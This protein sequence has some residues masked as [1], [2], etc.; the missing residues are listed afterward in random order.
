MPHNLVVKIRAGDQPEGEEAATEAATAYDSPDDIYITIKDEADLVRAFEEADKANQLVQLYIRADK[1]AAAAMIPEYMVDMADPRQS[2]TMQMVSFYRFFPEPKDEAALDL[3]TKRLRAV[4]EPFGALGRI[5]VAS[6]GINAQMAVPA[7]VFKNFAAACNSLD[8]LKGVFLN[9]DRQVAMDVYQEDPAFDALHVR[10]REQ[11]VADGGL[12]EVK[13]YDWQDCGTPMEPEEWHAT[14]DDPNVIVLDCRNEFESEVGRFVSSEPLNTS[15]FRESWDVLKTRL[16]DVPKD[17]PI[18][19]Y[20]TGGIRCIKVGAYLKQELGFANVARLEGGIVSYAR[21]L[22]EKTGQETGLPNISP[23]VGGVIPGSKFKGINYVFDNRLGERITEDVLSECDQCGVASDVYV[24]CANPLCHVRF[25]QCS[26]CGSKFNA[27]CSRGCMQAVE[28]MKSRP[29]PGGYP[30]PPKTI[31]PPGVE[32]SYPLGPM[33]LGRSTSGA[34]VASTAARP[35]KRA[36]LQPGPFQNAALNRAFDVAIDEFTAAE[37]GETQEPDLLARL[38]QETNEAFPGGAHMVSG[39]SQGRLLSSITREIGARHVLEIGTFT[40]YATLCLAEG[41]EAKGG[42]VVTL[43]IDDRAGTIARKY[44]SESPDGSKVDLKIE[45]AMDYLNRLAAMPEEDR[46]S[47]DIILLDGDKKRYKDYYEMILGNN[48]LSP[49][50]LMIADNVLWKGLVPE[51]ARRRAM[52]EELPVEE[53]EAM[54]FTKRQVQLADVL[55]DFNMHVRGDH[56]TEQSYIPIRDGLLVIRWKG[57]ER[58]ALPK[59]SS[60]E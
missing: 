52:G 44:F 40:G 48:L 30:A 29:A 24:N 26:S 38:N 20:C 59:E 6:E 53:Y 17:Q 54:G 41:V 15:F 16:K 14:V 18:L 39:H 11:V 3:L 25:I 8:D 56:R 58:T 7:N 5:Y 50:G 34:S 4:W 35:P 45:P 60:E 9:T 13:E 47:F 1:T 57:F 2:A 49:T 22:R 12:S 23:S 46:P 42:K 33:P 32:E 43:E 28:E 55:H 19:T 10:L 21:H 37:N 31:Y 36:W 27:C 51:L